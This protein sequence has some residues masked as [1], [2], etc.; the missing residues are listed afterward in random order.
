MRFCYVGNANGGGKRAEVV[1]PVR[2]HGIRSPILSATER[3]GLIELRPK[4][5]TSSARDS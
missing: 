1:C 2:W 5:I 4:R 3:V